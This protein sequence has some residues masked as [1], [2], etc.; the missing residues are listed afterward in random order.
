MTNVGDSTIGS[1]LAR[2]RQAEAVALEAWKAAA[3][4]WEQLSGR[5]EATLDPDPTTNVLVAQGV[6]RARARAW[7][8]ADR[9]LR[10][11]LERA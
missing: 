9:E 8:E 6:M 11:A 4:T 3:R 1:P 5:H 2:L 10:A 7:A